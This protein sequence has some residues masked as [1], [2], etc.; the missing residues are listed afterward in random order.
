MTTCSSVLPAAR[1]PGSF[2]SGQLTTGQPGPVPRD[3]PSQPNLSQHG[4]VDAGQD[5]PDRRGRGDRPGRAVQIL[6][7]G[8]D[9]H[10]ADRAGAVGD[11]DGDLD[12]HP[13]GIVACRCRSPSVASLSAAV[14]PIRSASSASSTVPACDT[15]PVPSAVMVGGVLLV[16]TCTCEVPLWLGDL[17]PSARTESQTGEA[18]SLVHGPCRTSKF[19]RLLQHRGWFLDISTSRREVFAHQDQSGR[20]VTRPRPRSLVSAPRACLL[21]AH[22]HRSAA[23]RTMPPR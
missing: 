1:E 19:R 7:V 2:R 23:P 16:V 12:Q 8:Q 21:T 4:G 20:V 17:V 6:L 13:A 3:G 5:P 22:S 14:S 15:T 10:I 11:R 9:L 18:L